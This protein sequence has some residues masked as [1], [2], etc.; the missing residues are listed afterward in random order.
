MTKKILIALAALAVLLA[1]SNVALAPRAVYAQQYGQGVV[2][3]EKAPEP[4]VHEPVPADLGDIS[5]ALLGGGLLSAS[6]IL[7]YLSR[8]KAPSSFEIK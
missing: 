1:T 4:I 2:L 3:G 6:G 7:L 5:P 8:R